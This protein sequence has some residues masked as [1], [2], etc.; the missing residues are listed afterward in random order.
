VIPEDGESNTPDPE[1][2][3]VSTLADTGAGSPF[4]LDKSIDL[5]SEA[6][7]DV[8]DEC[9]VDEDLCL[10]PLLEQEGLASTLAQVESHS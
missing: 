8:E 4:E 3:A 5:S 6:W 1:A 10:F 7:Y 2:T 9:F